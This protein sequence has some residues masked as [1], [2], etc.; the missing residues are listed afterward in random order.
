MSSTGPTGDSIRLRTVFF[1]TSGFAEAVFRRLHAVHE[2]AAAVTR[3]PR[4]AGRGHRPRPSRIHRAAEELGVP[5]LEP[6]GFRRPAAVEAVTRLRADCLV[7]A[8][9]GRIL[10]PALL[11]STPLGAVNVHASLLPALRG[12]APAVWAVAR[13]LDRTGVTTMLMDEGLDTGPILLR[14]P[15]D[16]RPDDTAGSLL[17][18]L[19]PIGADLLLETLAGLAEMEIEPLPQDDAAASEAPPVRKTDAAVD[20][21]LDAVEVERRIRA[22]QPAPVA[23]TAFRPADGSLELLR[24]HVAQV[25]LESEPFEAAPGTTRRTGSRGDPG[26]EVACGGGRLLLRE[27]QPA[28]SRRMAVAEFVRGGRLP[29]V[30]T[31]GGTRGGTRGPD[32]AGEMRFAAAEEAAAL[33][34]PPDAAAVAP[35]P[36]DTAEAAEAPRSKTPA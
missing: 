7:V 27:V 4:P 21:R 28:G 5:V 25:G 30:G 24:I 17:A 35:G 19:A 9:Y 16:L 36:D 1:G 10:P 2:V 32:A 11:D 34:G 13:G 6:K 8:D 26:L 31:H 33:V 22:F 18:R 15:E 14:R 3:P 29:G 20:W 12:A 23:F